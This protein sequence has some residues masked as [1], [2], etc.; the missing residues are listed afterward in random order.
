MKKI[1]C[2]L[3]TIFI[4]SSVFY[5]QSTIP[6]IITDCLR[7]EKIPFHPSINRRWYH[8]AVRYFNDLHAQSQPASTESDNERITEDGIKIIFDIYHYQH[9]KWI[10]FPTTGL[11]HLQVLNSVGEYIADD[12]D[13]PIQTPPTSDTPEAVQT[14]PSHSLLHRIGAILNH[15]AGRREAQ[16]SK[17]E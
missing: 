6:I 13:I 12:L 10:V 5:S 11:D 1:L 9:T 2:F 15:F 16:R 3:S 8:A 17:T 4:L 7:K 14:P